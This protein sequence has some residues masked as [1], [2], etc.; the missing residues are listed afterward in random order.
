MVKNDWTVEEV[1]AIYHSSLISLISRAHAVHCHYHSIDE[2]QVCRLLSFKTGGCTEDCKYCAQSARYQ[3][4]VAPLPL[5]QKKEMIA[6]AKEA[7]AHGATRICIGAA[8]KG[9]RDGK[10]F[11]T[12]LE[13]VNLSP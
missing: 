13:T 2:V 9:I 6:Q 1:G 3:T 4:S 8:W 7:M 12:I 11:D 10:A 5:M